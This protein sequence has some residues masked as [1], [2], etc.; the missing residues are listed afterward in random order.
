MVNSLN[1]SHEST[2]WLATWQALWNMLT[3]GAKASP[4]Q[5][6]AVQLTWGPAEW[7]LTFKRLYSLA[8][9]ASFWPFCEALSPHSAA[10]IERLHFPSF[11]S[12]LIDGPRWSQDMAPLNQDSISPL[13]DGNV[14]AFAHKEIRTRLAQIRF[15]LIA[16]ESVW[17]NCD[18]SLSKTNFLCG[19]KN[20]FRHWHAS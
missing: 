4:S 9:R 19:R 17:F 7:D 18:T 20:L 11:I 2:R 1:I 3:G 5:W 14:S 10:L 16:A 15:F 8:L 13:N 6:S 12:Q